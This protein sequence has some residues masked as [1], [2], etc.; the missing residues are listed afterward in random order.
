MWP[1]KLILVFAAV[2]A[3]GVPAPARSNNSPILVIESYHAEYA[4]DAAYKR[5]LQ[6]V[7]GDRYTLRFFQMNTKRLLPAEYATQAD[8][9]WQCYLKTQPQLVILGDDN[10]LKYLG[11]RF[12]E[13]ETPTIYLGI[14]NNPRAYLGRRA[15][16]ITGVLERPLIKRSVPVIFQLVNEPLK[17]LLV[18]FDSGTTS[19]VSLSHLFQNKSQ[20]RLENV[21]VHLRFIGDWDEWRQTV[22]SAKEDGYGAIVIGLYHTINDK[23]GQHV[24]ED[25]V[26]AWTSQHTP[27]PPFGFWDFSVGVNKTIGGLVLFGESQGTAAAGIA[28]Q[29][30]EDGKQPREIYPVIGDRGRYLFSRSGLE[31]FK[32]TLPDFIRS[33]SSF[34]E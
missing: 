21:E 11:P 12:L 15:R 29:I 14:N 22:L 33:Q 1:F 13:T 26:L 4:W 10:A 20:T 28:L 17:K 2:F 25:E 18:M 32:L 16:E 9:A 23:S 19:K 7:L 24:N 8:L 3:F 34:T 31:R 27:V 5:G 6:R 30:L